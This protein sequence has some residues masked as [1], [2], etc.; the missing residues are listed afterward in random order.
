[1]GC[2]PR[3]F[4]V[5]VANSSVIALSSGAI[6]LGL[7]RPGLPDLTSCKFPEAELNDISD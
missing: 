7:L 4:A 3:S 6:G 1:M 2:T 5:F